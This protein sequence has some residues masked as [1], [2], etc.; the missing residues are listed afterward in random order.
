VVRRRARPRGLPDFRHGAI[1][2]AAL[3]RR[4][5]DSADAAPPPI[6]RTRI[7]VLTSA[8]RR[9]V[10]IACDATI[11]DA[12]R[13]RLRSQKRPVPKRTEKILLKPL[14]SLL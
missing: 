7:R 6:E 1:S 9:A 2:F 8:P 5:N 13:R 12:L 4:V 11:G 10:S 14:V 3:E